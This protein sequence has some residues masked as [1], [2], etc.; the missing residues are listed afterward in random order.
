MSSLGFLF[1][2]YIPNLGVE[3][4]SNLRMPKGT[5]QKDLQQNLPFLDKGTGKEQ[6]SKTDIWDNTAPLQ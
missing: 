5:G 3:E 6:P 2:S 4:P 1:T